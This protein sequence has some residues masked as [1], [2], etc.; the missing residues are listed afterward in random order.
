MTYQPRTKFEL[1]RDDFRRARRLA[2][3]NEIIRKLRGQPVELLP[4]DEVSPHIHAQDG[5]NRGLQ[6]IPLDAIVG[7][8]GRYADFTRDFLPRS[9]A[10]Q[11]RWARVK[12]KF[13]NLEDMPPIQ[14]YQV[15]AV[16]FV[17]DGNH[18]VSIA[19]DSGATQIRAYITEF[20]A[21]IEITTDTD[22]DSMI[23]AVEQAEFFAKTQLN[24]R[25]P[26]PNLRI[27]SPGR[28]KILEGQINNLLK[29]HQRDEN[30][31][32]SFEGAAQLWYE[33]MYL[34]V[35][36]TIRNHRL[37]ENFP[38]RTET[39]LYVWI[40]QHQEDLSAALGWAIHPEDAAS[41][42]ADQ[43]SPRAEH[44]ASRLRERILDSVIPNPIEA[45]P[46]AGEWRQEQIEKQRGDKLFSRIL[47]SLSGSPHSWQALQQAIIFAQR[48]DAQILG[49]HMVKNKNTRASAATQAV[50]EKFN[51]YCQDAGIPGELALDVGEITPTIIERSRWSDLV[52]VHLAHPPSDNILRRL[53]PGFHRL[54]QGC[55]RPILAVPRAFPKL[56]NLLL[57]YDG[58][59]KADEALF[60]AVYLA[61]KWKLPL[62]VLV[63]LDGE[64]FPKRA[65]A[66]AR[67][68]LSSHKI[69]GDIHFRHGPVAKTIM[70]T[71]A[72]ANTELI[73]MGGYSRPPMLD[74]MVGSSVDQILRSA[75]CPILICR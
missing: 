36:E 61:G 44:V 28:Y 5:R 64:R 71:A 60:V 27:T 69:I 62:S 58:S 22:L 46:R 48:E 8:V 52:V 73:I 75:T 55:P 18:R 40:S 21:D 72:E 41:D 31:A 20:Q 9:G 51:T 43:F 19:R 57:A 74:M 32:F 54:V 70:Q 34:P 30:A 2:A 45:G 35:I 10:L 29:K 42:L 25:Q 6:H 12:S 47:V 11:D 49:L 1:A 26:I 23:L 4:F 39:D 38:D 59:A 17:L 14:V 37:L 66:R 15:G 16:Y 24:Q 56:D 33:D 53:G 7:S 68:Y 13:H 63:V 3:T 50:Q 65:A 67:W